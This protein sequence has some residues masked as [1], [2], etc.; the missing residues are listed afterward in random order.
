MS[1]STVRRTARTLRATARSLRNGSPL[2]A[3]RASTV[4]QSQHQLSA[5]W[6]TGVRN[7]GDLVGPPIVEHITGSRP[8]LTNP[9]STGKLL[10]VGSILANAR[11]GDTVWGSGA[12]VDQRIA[13]RG[14]TTLALRGPLSV[15]LA[16][17]DPSTPL[18]DPALLLPTFYAPQPS[19]H[20]RIGFVPHYVDLAIASTL[21]PDAHII[22]VTHK[23]WRTTVDSIAACDVI[24][25]SSLH[26]LIVAEAYG[27]PAV[28]SQPHHPIIGDDFKFRDYFGATSREL[29]QPLGPSFTMHEIR[30]HMSAPPIFATEQLADVL[31]SW[32]DALPA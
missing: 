1:G 11:A 10:T 25:S 32:F 27:I 21:T 31:H 24:V 13:L 2:S 28:W 19:T 30:T 29:P 4:H 23:D 18:G 17:A 8:R 12:I 6:F 9:E 22:D 14:V 3:L 26:G 5:Y 7:F 20:H 15:Q 16:H